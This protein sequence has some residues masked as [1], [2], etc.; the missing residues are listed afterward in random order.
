[1][2]SP[3]SSQRCIQGVT[4]M[5]VMARNGRTGWLGCRVDY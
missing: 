4:G 3:A 1:M 2:P 5:E